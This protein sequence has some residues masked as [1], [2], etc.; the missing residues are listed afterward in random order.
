MCVCVC[1][2]LC[3]FGTI[4]FF[5][6]SVGWFGLWFVTV[7]LCVHVSADCPVGK[8]YHDPISSRPSGLARAVSEVKPARHAVHKQPEATCLHICLFA[9]KSQRKGSHCLRTPVG[10]TEEL[11]A[12]VSQVGSS[13]AAALPA[14]C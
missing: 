13:D 9:A 8:W 11:L 7:C 3:W 12:C 1:V 2:C 4:L 10:K 5:I 6:F 14:C